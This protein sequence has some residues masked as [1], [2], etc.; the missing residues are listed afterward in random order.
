MG[1]HWAQATSP[2]HGHRPRSQLTLPALLPPALHCCSTASPKSGWSRGK[3]GQWLSV[4]CQDSPWRW[5]MQTSWAGT[6]ISLPPEKAQQT[7]RPCCHPGCTWDRTGEGSWGANCLNGSW[8]PYAGCS[9]AGGSP[10]NRS[11]EWA[12]QAGWATWL[13][14]E[15]VA[16]G[17]SARRSFCA[18]SDTSLACVALL[19]R[20]LCHW[21]IGIGVFPTPNK[22]C[23][24]LRRCGT[25]HSACFTTSHT[26]TCSVILPRQARAFS[27]FVSCVAK[28]ACC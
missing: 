7:T 26:N 5:E 4:V 19:Q 21:I 9:A 24:D 18:K 14:R 16:M 15:H 27:K 13:G 22:A 20:S 3:S 6:H 11:A 25:V 2:K 28:G 10:H 1:G 12:Q 23:L 17:S 8:L